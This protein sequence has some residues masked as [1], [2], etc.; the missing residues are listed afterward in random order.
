MRLVFVHGMRQE[1]L[2][3]EIL[4]AVWTRALTDKWSELGLA[5]LPLSPEMP[6]YGDVLDQLT[7][8][9]GD[10]VG[11]RLRG[12]EGTSEEQGKILREMASRF[13]IDEAHVRE[14]VG[15]EIVARGPLNWEYS[16]AL[17]RLLDKRLP[18][19]GRYGLKFVVQVDAYLRRPHIT[20]AVDKIVQP[21]LEGE[22][23]VIVAHSLGSVV[24]YRLLANLA[25]PPV[26]LFITLGSPLAFGVVKENIVPPKLSKPNQV[27]S[28]INA[29]DDRDYV[30]TYAS[31]DSKTFCEGIENWTDIRNRNEDPHHIGDY[32]SN[33][34]VARAIHAA[35]RR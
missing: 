2:D 15:A 27:E 9:T 20:G 26:P 8:Q 35:L 3:P 1:G 32:L 11:V 30:A 14:E 5:P 23:Y 12:G 4:K 31:L 28:W 6:F 13:G 34:N 24:A 21:Y 29:T 16:Q 33:E 18:A 19:F 17:I 22:P 7:T 25:G 10:L